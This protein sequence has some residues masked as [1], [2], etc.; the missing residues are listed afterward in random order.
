MVS[1]RRISLTPLEL[2]HRIFDLFQECPTGIVNEDTFKHVYG[3]FFP[4][5][6]MIAKKSLE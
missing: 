6:G 2:Q 3:Q 1:I 5:G 4:Q